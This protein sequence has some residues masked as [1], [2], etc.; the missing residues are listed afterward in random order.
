MYVCIYIYIYIYIPRVR[1]CEEGW[2]H[3]TS[4]NA[5]EDA[6][7]VVVRGDT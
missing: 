3:L 2:E 6:Y 7:I 4:L 5:I 1:D